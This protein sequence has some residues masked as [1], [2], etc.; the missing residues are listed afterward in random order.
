MRQGKEFLVVFLEALLISR[1]FFV[2]PHHVATN[3]SRIVFSKYFKVLMKDFVKHFYNSLQ[4]AIQQAHI[5]TSI[6]YA[7]FKTTHIFL[8]Q[9]FQIKL[10]LKALPIMNIHCDQIACLESNS[11]ASLL[12][13]K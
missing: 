11:G 7:W 2:N 9:W 1:R 4:Y 12:R 5:F 13:K 10:I 3:I 8:E 6:K